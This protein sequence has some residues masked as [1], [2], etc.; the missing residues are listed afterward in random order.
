[1]VVEI[2]CCHAPAQ[3]SVF[4]SKL[5]KAYFHSANYRETYK[6]IPSLQDRKLRNV[7]RKETRSNMAR[8]S[9]SSGIPGA[10]MPSPYNGGARQ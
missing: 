6:N 10:E 1:M 7:K 2:K 4:I 5:R 3:E 9:F 8:S